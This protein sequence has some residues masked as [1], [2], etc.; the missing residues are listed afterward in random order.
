[1]DLNDIITAYNDAATF[2]SGYAA[3][4]VT[5]DRVVD[6]TDVVLTYNN[7]NAFVSKVTP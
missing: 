1:M 5:G 3:T 6:L 4:D 7:S 2:I